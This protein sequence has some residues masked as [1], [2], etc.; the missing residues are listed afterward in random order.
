MPHIT[1]MFDNLCVSSPPSYP[2]DGGGRVSEGGSEPGGP[3]TALAR[4][5]ER[6]VSFCS[7]DPP[8]DVNTKPAV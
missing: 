3:S 2:L 5:A 1:E 4:R 6:E 8:G 7:E